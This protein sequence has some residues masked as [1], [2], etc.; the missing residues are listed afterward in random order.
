[1]A[2]A[3][4]PEII[5]EKIRQDSQPTGLVCGNGEIGV[6]QD[7]QRRTNFDWQALG[8]GRVSHILVKDDNLNF[9]LDITTQT[10]NNEALIIISQNQK[11]GK[12]ITVDITVGHKNFIFDL[13][14]NFGQI[15]EKEKIF[16]R[17]I[18]E[19][20]YLKLSKNRL[21]FA[22]EISE[23]LLTKEVMKKIVEEAL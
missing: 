12:F 3:D 17:A 13:S 6:S 7:G 18:S 14:T 23:E 10:F 1:M 4:R 8:Q 22:L 20:F 11:I 15:S 2:L 19:K 5:S 9:N 21:I 16:I